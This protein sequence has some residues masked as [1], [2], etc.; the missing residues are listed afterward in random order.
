MSM[1]Q[2][3]PGSSCL[4]SALRFLDRLYTRWIQYG[5]FTAQLRPHPQKW[6][7]HGF[8][9][10]A[11]DKHI[12]RRIWEYPYS[13]F[14]AMRE[15]MIARAQLLPYTYTQALRAWLPADGATPRGGTGGVAGSGG[16]PWLRAL[17]VDAPGDA[18]AFDPKYLNEFMFG[19]ALL[20]AP[21]TAPMARPANLSR[22]DVFL[23]ATAAVW[24]ERG[25]G[26]CFPGGSVAARNYTLDETPV[27]VKGGT[28]LPTAERPSARRA[29]DGTVPSPGVPP[30]IGAAADPSPATIVWEVFGVSAAVTSA[31]AGLL[32]EDDGT[33]T[34]YAQTGAWAATRASYQVAGNS[35]ELAVGPTDGSFA[36]MR[37]ARDY[38]WRVFG[39]L[40][41]ASV[42]ASSGS[43]G[44]LPWTW[45]AE[46]LSLTIRARSV[47]VAQGA[48]ATVTFAGPVADAALCGPSSGFA[49]AAKR[50]R[51]VKEAVDQDA[52]TT[53]P[54]MLLNHVDA[55]VVRMAEAAAGTHPPG[56]AAVSAELAAYRGS[57]AAAVAL[58]TRGAAG[59]GGRPSKGLCELIVAWLG[60]AGDGAC[61]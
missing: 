60:G 61:L 8:G 23:P 19:D 7:S 45:D 47:D 4:L 49:R 37:T 10:N 59:T 28:L 27:F 46:T 15:A 5:A 29:A 3:R 14:D 30:L 55:A 40:P 9:Q 21:V 12:E 34:A 48:R 31:G 44:A 52:R 35:L 53:L 57:V 20:V 33:S 51:W 1:A 17:Y 58:H 18:R 22:A 41:P 26:A 24:V 39:V 50:V 38:V 2:L 56:A 16:V 43:G 13:Y 11:T 25:G 42:V 32:L 6:P 54:S 36:G